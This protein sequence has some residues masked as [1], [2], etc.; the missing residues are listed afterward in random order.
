MQE[1]S[2]SLFLVRFRNGIYNF[3]CQVFYQNQ[4]EV[5]NITR[6]KAVLDFYMPVLFQGRLGNVFFL[7][8]CDL[9]TCERYF[10]MGRFDFFLSGYIWPNEMKSMKYIFAWI[11]ATWNVVQVPSGNQTVCDLWDRKILDSFYKIIKFLIEYCVIIYFKNWF[12]F[13]W[14]NISWYPELSFCV[15][16]KI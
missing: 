2:S 13:L 1:K 12:Y 11:L 5:L 16:F 15:C 8:T 9:R 3:S 7:R 10:Y 6:E 4:G 14:C